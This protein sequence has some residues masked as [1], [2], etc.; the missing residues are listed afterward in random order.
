MRY[1]CIKKFPAFVWL[2]IFFALLVF[3][4]WPKEISSLLLNGTEDLD[5]QCSKI[6]GLSIDQGGIS[7]QPKKEVVTAVK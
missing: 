1:H 6:D 3:L 5:K 7:Y 2:G 4:V